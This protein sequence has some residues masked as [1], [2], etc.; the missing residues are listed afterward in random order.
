MRLYA[1]G[2][3]P[4]LP[5]EK[6]PPRRLAIAA[7]RGAAKTTLKSLILPIH[8]TLHQGERYIVLISATLKQARR[9]LRNIQIE[10]QTNRRLHQRLTNF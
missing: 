6:R 4:A 5:L 10:L 9:R 2:L 8:A 1:K 7:P 3:R